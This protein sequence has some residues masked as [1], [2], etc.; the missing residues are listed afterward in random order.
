MQKFWPTMSSPLIVLQAKAAIRVQ[1]SGLTSALAMIRSPMGPIFAS[2]STSLASETTTVTTAVRT[3]FS[4]YRQSNK[5]YWLQYS[6]LDPR[7]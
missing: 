2:V 7:N 5:S 3:S 4:S 1:P 6:R